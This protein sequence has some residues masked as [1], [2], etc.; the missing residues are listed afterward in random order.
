MIN[1]L[2]FKTKDGDDQEIELAVMRPTPQQEKE[3][4]LEQRKA[5][6]YF[7]EKGLMLR[8]K[9]ESF[10]RSQNLWDDEKQKELEGID[11]T[12]TDGYKKLY[13]EGGLKL[14]EAKNIA[15]DM[16]AARSRRISL[17][18]DYL[19]L[20]NNSVEGQADDVKQNYLVSVCTV[21]NDTGKRYFESLADYDSKA[22]TPA[23]YDAAFNLSKLTH[24]ITDD[25]EK[26]LPENKFLLKYKLCDD[27]LRLVNKDGHLVDVDGK[28][29][30]E[31]YHYVTEEGK[32]C[33]RDGTLLEEKKEPAPFL[34]EDGQPV[35][36]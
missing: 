23:A 15:L 28:L 33:Y 2:V 21:Y 22:T 3:A 6:R 1:K 26:N 14:S 7:A 8:A 36:L 13:E 5:F 27:K 20:D 35:L 12:L 16:R 29:I 17:T 9:L 32:Q 30:D 18:A 31:N 24:D 11:K 34:D 25:F 4:D 19:A 10:L